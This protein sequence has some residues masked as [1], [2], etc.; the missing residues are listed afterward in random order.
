MRRIIITPENWNP[1]DMP[2]AIR[3]LDAGVERL[4][5]RT[6]NAAESQLLQ[7]IE[8]VPQEYRGRVSIHE[9]LHLALTTGVGG[10]HLNSRSGVVPEGFQGMVS[11]SCHSIEALQLYPELDYLF[12]SP[13]FDSISKEGYE[14]KFGYEELIAAK[15]A[16]IISPRIIALGGITPQRVERCR[17]MGFG[18]VAM[19][20]A[21]FNPV[22]ADR[23]ALQYIT[24]DIEDDSALL[25]RVRKVMEGGC[26]WVQLRLKASTTARILR[27]GREMSKLCREFD[28][29]FILDD[30]VELVTVTG[31]DGVHLGK[32]DMPVDQARSILGAGYIIGA[33]ANTAED[34]L[35]HHSRGADYI[36]LGPLRF[37]TTKRNLSPTLG[38]DGYRRII[39]E[40]RKAGVSLPVVGIGGV[41]ATDLAPLKETGVA[42][43]AV[44]GAI[45]QFINR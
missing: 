40:V 22:R 28:A 42:G 2:R 21:A 14:A 39:S 34:I 37:T 5:L 29:T 7:L 32:N 3:L 27:V 6:V 30:H 11:R 15:E 38:Y 10:V 18:G 45:D 31:A 4:H 20:G 41:V 33:T 13:V 35:M 16:G 9:H 43:V 1:E 19:M 44:C 8:A 12:L 25:E 23:F 36:G 26:R 24:P 17:E